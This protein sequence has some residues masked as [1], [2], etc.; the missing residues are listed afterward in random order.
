MKNVCFVCTA[1]EC[2]SPMAEVIFQNLLKQA[3]VKDVK[4]SSAGIGASEGSKM[5]LFAKR[6]LKTLGY[7]V[8]NKKSKQLKQIA[9]NVMYVAMSKY[10]KGYLNKKNVLTF[11]E[12]VGGQDVADPY[13]EKQDTYNKTANQI[14]QYCKILLAKITKLQN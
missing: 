2:R 8:G 13:G 14:E 10:E 5:S 4:V 7:K 12:L 9:S 1:N 6:A 11:G 3:G